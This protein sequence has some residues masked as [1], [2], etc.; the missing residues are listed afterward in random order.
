MT[1]MWYVGL[2]SDMITANRQSTRT[3]RQRL[4]KYSTSSVLVP[5]C[6]SLNL[7]AELCGMTELRCR[8]ILS[9]LAWLTAPKWVLALIQ[10]LNMRLVWGRLW[11]NMERRDS[12]IFM[13]LHDSQYLVMLANSRE[14][15]NY[16]CQW[17]DLIHDTQ[18]EKQNGYKGI[19]QGSIF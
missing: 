16:Q 11:Q 3:A 14:Q 13:L 6:K 9:I 8:M 5:P 2:I 18:Q 4:P 10:I 15:S 12:T 17:E 7:L 1:L 19:K